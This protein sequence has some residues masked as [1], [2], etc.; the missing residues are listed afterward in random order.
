M[1]RLLEM[2]KDPV[3]IVRLTALIMIDRFIE[4]EGILNK[5]SIR[6]QQREEICEIFI[7]FFQGWLM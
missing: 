6:I 3:S 4:K 5:L 1:E 2:C 7:D